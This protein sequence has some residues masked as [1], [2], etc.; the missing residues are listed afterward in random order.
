MLAAREQEQLDALSA[1]AR[2]TLGAGLLGVYLFGSAVHGGLRPESDLDVLAVAARR[3]TLDEKRRLALALMDLS[4]HP[5][6]PPGSR[7]L[8][9]TMLVGEEVRPW[10]TG[11]MPRFDFQY[12]DWLRADFEAGRFE[13]WPPEN[14]DV[15]AL[16]TMTLLHGRTLAGPPPDALLEAPPPAE[17]ERLMVADLPSLLA[18]LD[19]DTR[20]VVLTLARIWT[21][22]ATDRIRSKDGAADWALVRLPVELRE[23]L[24]VARAAYRGEDRDDWS[25]KLPA[26][27]A[28]AAWM[29]DEIARLT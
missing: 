2:D 22:L 5:G 10:P 28:T 27:H 6:S 17:L 8:E 25:G 3:L 1:L 4:R 26:V 24:A 14:P 19:T 7:R 21:T 16:V 9:L 12:G 29:V 13:P 15:G 18:D 20:N 11:R 23:P